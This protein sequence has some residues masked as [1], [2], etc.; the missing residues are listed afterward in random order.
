MD[1]ATRRR[2]INAACLNSLPFLDQA[3]AITAEEADH[4]NDTTAER[5]GFTP[6]QIRQLEAA[7]APRAP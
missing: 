2:E 4:I 6:A 5:L 3:F 1:T 7:I